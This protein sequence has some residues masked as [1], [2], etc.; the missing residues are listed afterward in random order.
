MVFTSQV[1]N[2]IFNL[3]KRNWFKK[4]FFSKKSMDTPFWFFFGNTLFG[5]K[6]EKLRFKKKKKI[7]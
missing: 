3:N 4:K 5:K 7:F 1:T 6:Y 2:L